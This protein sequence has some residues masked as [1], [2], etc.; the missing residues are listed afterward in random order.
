MQSA[1]KLGVPKVSVCLV[2]HTLDIGP[3]YNP[4]NSIEE[5][6]IE[7]LEDSHIHEYKGGLTY[8]SSR[9]RELSTYLLNL[10]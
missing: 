6:P 9:A 10:N 4:I 3:R 7:R 1:C 8:T 2:S 5:F